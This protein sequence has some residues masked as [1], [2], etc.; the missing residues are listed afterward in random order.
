LEH[1]SM[2]AGRPDGVLVPAG[3]LAAGVPS[4]QIASAP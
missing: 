1:G 4:E 2:V 3:R